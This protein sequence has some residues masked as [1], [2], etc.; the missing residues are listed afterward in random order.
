[1]LTSLGFAY[2]CVVYLNELACDTPYMADQQNQ[3]IN[4][5]VNKDVVYQFQKKNKLWRDFC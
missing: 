5:L 4:G 1:M 3:L 2:D